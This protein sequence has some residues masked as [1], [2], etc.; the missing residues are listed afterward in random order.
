MNF[1]METAFSWAER[2]DV[3]VSAG[4]DE[5]GKWFVRMELRDSRGWFPVVCFSRERDRKKQ[6]EDQFAQEVEKLLGK[7]CQKAREERMKAYTKTEVFGKA[8]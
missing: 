3:P 2:N 6:T 4:R 5:A 1:F 8:A 7:T